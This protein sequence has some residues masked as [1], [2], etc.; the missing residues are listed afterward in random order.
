MSPARTGT[1]E[2]RWDAASAFPGECLGFFF[3]LGRWQDVSW[4]SWCHLSFHPPGCLGSCDA[5]PELPGKG[6]GGH[7]VPKTAAAAANPPRN[8]LVPQ[9]LISRDLS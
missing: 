6:F 2:Q 7:V 9:D 3:P 5:T 8:V 1:S 4:Q